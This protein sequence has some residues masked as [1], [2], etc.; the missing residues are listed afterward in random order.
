MR[1]KAVTWMF[2]QR[3]P[4]AFEM[5]PL[6]STAK[7]SLTWLTCT[8]YWSHFMQS[9]E[10]CQKHLI[11]QLDM[12]SVN[13]DWQKI[14]WSICAALTTLQSDVLGS[15]E[16]LTKVMGLTEITLFSALVVSFLCANSWWKFHTN[17]CVTEHVQWSKYYPGSL[18]V[19][20]LVY[21]MLSII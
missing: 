6:V 1:E 16:L 8:S 12:F 2:P 15:E 3:F 17:L 9:S 14:H 21:Q 11:W 7:K 18:L 5:I 13:C 4:K 19:F 10:C 20:R